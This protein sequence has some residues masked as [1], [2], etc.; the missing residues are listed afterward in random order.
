VVRVVV[1]RV[2]VV[3]VVVVRGDVVRVVVVR[4]DVVRGVA[5]GTAAGRAVRAAAEFDRRARTATSSAGQ[6]LGLTRRER[7]LPRF[8]PAVEARCLSDV[9]RWVREDGWAH[10]VPR[11]MVL[12]NWALQRGYDPAAL[13]DW[14]DRAFVDGRDWVMLP[15]VVGMS[16]YADGGRLAT[17]PYASGGAYIKRMNDYCGGCRYDPSVRWGRTPV[18]SAPGTGRSC[19]ATASA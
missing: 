17:K 10:H 7:R 13:T 2:V 8:R 1:V 6:G 15:N 14:F 4:G 3:R 5:D 16:E 19:T 11:L 12:G 18:R 9:L